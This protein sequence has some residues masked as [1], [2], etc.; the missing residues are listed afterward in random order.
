MTSTIQKVEYQL[1][2]L[3][4][5]IQKSRFLFNEQAKEKFLQQ[6]N[7]I[8]EKLENAKEPSLQIGILGG[9]GV[10][11]STL[12]NALAGEAIS[13][14]S[15]RRPHTDLVVVYRHKETPLPG[16]IPD[17]FLNKPQITHSNSSIAHLLIYDFPDFD[18]IN[19]EHEKKVL[20]L[21]QYLDIVVWTTSPEKYA[22]LLFYEVLNKS[23]MHQDN[24]IFVL[25]K[26]DQ[27]QSLSEKPPRQLAHIIGDFSLKLKDVQI[28]KPQIYA[29]SAKEAL[30]ND[31][32]EWWRKDFMLFKENLFRERNQKEM[33]LIKQANI[34][35]ELK[36][37]VHAIQQSQSKYQNLPSEL[38][39]VLGEFEGQFPDQKS[40]FQVIEK[41]FTGQTYAAIRAKIAAQQ[42][43]L[44][45]I[46][47]LRRL[48]TREKV[49]KKGSVERGGWESSISAHDDRLDLVKKKF[50]T[51]FDRM[52]TLFYRF[53]LDQANKEIQFLEQEVISEIEAFL[54]EGKGAFLRFM[55]VLASPPGRLRATIRKGKQ[56]LWITFPALFFL[57][58][59]TGPDNLRSFYANP[60]ISRGFFLVFNVFLSIYTAR[61]LIALV[62]LIVIE[63]LVLSVLVTRNIRKIDRE[64]TKQMDEFNEYMAEMLFKSVEKLREKINHFGEDVIEEIEA[65]NYG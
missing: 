53:G 8:K 38:R 33:L 34:E 10:G 3:L 4:V 1:E 25:N 32:P 54:L 28:K 24:F 44:L 65:K 23:E 17:E 19:Q 7:A 21:L 22:D 29:F 27:I 52:A 59:L 26:V 5:S 16:D 48:V 50:G 9:T 15:D 46:Q 11:K 18:S 14:V 39:S 60:S 35:V 42:N 57:I 37:L 20:T 49:K 2:Q 45:P 55:E 51:V 58:T 40:T 62:A 6:I 47:L 63:I 30:H 61:G 56:F 13:S 43:D 12:I 41:F 31:V 64:I 36:K